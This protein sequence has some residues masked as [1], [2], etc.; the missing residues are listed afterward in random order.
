MWLSYLLDFNPLD[1]S[2]WSVLQEK[3]QVVPHASLATLPLSMAM[4]WDL[5]TLGGCHD[6]TW[7]CH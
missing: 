2:I 1:F 5:P 4:E 7:C 6:K 3:V